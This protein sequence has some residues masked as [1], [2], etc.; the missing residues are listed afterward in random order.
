MR[1]EFLI[2]GWVIF[3][4]GNDVHMGSTSTSQSTSSTSGAME[5]CVGRMAVDDCCCLA[6]PESG[7]GLDTVCEAESLCPRIGVQC[8]YGLEDCAV[9][10][11]PEEMKCLL[12]VLSERRQGMLTWGKT[13]VTAPWG[14]N[15]FTELTRLYVIDD[16]AI[17]VTFAFEEKQTTI[18]DIARWRLRGP[19]FYA[20]CMTDPSLEKQMDCVELGVEEEPV[21]VCVASYAFLP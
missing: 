7:A 16:T 13:S 18:K 5:P 3:G 11:P 15:Q 20:Q 10:S 1:R 2:F 21:E 4:C 8:E 9:K 6:K 14:V 12:E 17:R 19:D